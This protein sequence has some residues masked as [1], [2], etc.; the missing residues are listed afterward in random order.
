MPCAV[1]GD[2][3]S[4]ATGRCRACYRFRQ[5]RGHDRRERDLQRLAERRKMMMEA[6]YDRMV[7]AEELAVVVRLARELH[8]R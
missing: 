5:R 3:D 7:E 2:A 4:Y 6:R 1:C 8:F